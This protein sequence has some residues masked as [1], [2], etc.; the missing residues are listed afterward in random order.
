MSAIF[1]PEGYQRVMPYLIIR[2]AE[3]FLPFVQKVFGATEKM[4]RRGDTGE[5]MHA[6]I[7]IGESTIMYANASEQWAPMT[8]G[9][10]V[11]VADADES[12]QLALDHGAS[13][14]MEPA[15]QPYGR[16]CGV[17]DP[18]GNTWWI[19]TTQSPS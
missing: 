14:V 7:Y 6:E 12:Y 9:L 13:T 16:S 3:E 11:H 18:F 8:A 15:D 17:L 1:I 10:Y 4:I 19:T 2:H 5:L